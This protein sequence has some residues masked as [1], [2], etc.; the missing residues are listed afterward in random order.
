MKAIA[1]ILLMA[2]AGCAST[3]F[4]QTETD[5]MNSWVGHTKAELVQ[6][7][8]P[9]LKIDS[10]QQGGEIFTYEKSVTIGQFPG[11]VYGTNTGIGYTQARPATITRVR[12]FY[13]NKE[14]KV[15]HWV[16]NGREGY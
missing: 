4:T 12:M 9:P 6:T 1:L 16:S 14:G 7:W 2:L 15:Y 10:D 11:Q 5:T 3:N 13:I 8:G